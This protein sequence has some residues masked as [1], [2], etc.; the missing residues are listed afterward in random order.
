M[1]ETGLLDQFA[2]LV[3]LKNQGKCGTHL[4][5]TDL[6]SQCRACTETALNA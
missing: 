4:E 1:M 5:R 6:K 2:R 3:T